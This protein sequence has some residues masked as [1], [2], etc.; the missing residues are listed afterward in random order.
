VEKL[1]QRISELS[2]ENGELRS[3]L[4]VPCFEFDGEKALDKEIDDTFNEKGLLNDFQKFGNFCEKVS[5]RKK[6]SL[7]RSC[8]FWFVLYLT[9]DLDDPNLIFEMNV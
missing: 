4:K 6:V 2:D 1:N 9:S 3:Q 7:K 5:F 8:D